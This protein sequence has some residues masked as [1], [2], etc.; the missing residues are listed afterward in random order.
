MKLLTEWCPIE[1]S[2]EMISESRRLNDG[3][4]ILIDLADQ[5]SMTI[6]HHIEEINNDK[7]S[8]QWRKNYLYHF[9]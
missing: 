6:Y 3:K 1:Y 5:N 7:I 9:Q 8:L 2:K 4:I